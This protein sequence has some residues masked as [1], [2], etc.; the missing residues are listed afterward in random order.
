MSRKTK[1]GGTMMEVEGY[2]PIEVETG[3][4]DFVQR[5]LKQY[6]NVNSGVKVERAPNYIG[7]YYTPSSSSVDIPSSS[8]RKK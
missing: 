1:A 8:K 4:E 2:G 7:R 6:M 3:S 5:V